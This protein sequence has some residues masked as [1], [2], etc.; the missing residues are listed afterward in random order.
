MHV[1]YLFVPHFSK[2]L[3][4]HFKNNNYLNHSPS[5]PC[6]HPAPPL[7]LVQRR[8]VPIRLIPG[9]ICPRTLYPG[10]FMSPYVSFLKCGTIFKVR[11][12]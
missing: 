9:M 4:R 5:P 7:Y 10:V 2:L 11:F 12:G 6:L 1:P 3:H 8:Y